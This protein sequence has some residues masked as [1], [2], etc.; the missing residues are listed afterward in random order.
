MDDVIQHYKERILKI[1]E[2]RGA[3]HVCLFGFM[4]RDEAREENDVDLLA[5]LKA[6]RSGYLFENDRC[7]LMTS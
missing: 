1:A 5:E 4:V 7:F 6:W 3:C 2:Q